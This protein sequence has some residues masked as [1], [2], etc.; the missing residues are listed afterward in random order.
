MLVGLG[1]A[2]LFGQD[3]VAPPPPGTIRVLILSG[4]SH[5]DWR[6]TTPFLRRILTDTRRFDVRISETPRG[7]T[8]ETLA[9]FEVVVDD[10]AG[11]RWGS[12][13]EKALEA[14]VKSGKGLVVTHGALG[15]FSGS[16]QTGDPHVDAVSRESAW[17]AFAKM[18]K[19][20]WPVPPPI[21]LPAVARFWDVKIAASTH[22]IV[23]GVKSE[24]ATADQIHRAGALLPGVEVLATARDNP[25]S[26]ADAH[27]EPVLWVSNYGLGRVVCVAL[28]HDLEAMQ[29]EAFITTFARGTEWAAT[30]RVTLASTWRPRQPE[31]GTVRALLVTGGHEHESAFYSLFEGCSDLDWLPVAT[32]QMAFESDLRKKYDVLILYDFSRDL[33]EKGKRNLRDFVESGK[34]VLVL[35]HA[36][37]SYQK[38]PW[39]YEEVVGGRYRLDAEGN[40]PASS[41]KD[42]QELF[43]TPEGAHPVTAGIGPFHLWD[44]PYKGMWI[45]SAI[46]PLLTTD[47]PSSDRAVAWISPYPKSRVVYI[48]LGHNHTTYGHP[49]Y[50]ALLH[51]AIL[52][53]A[54][55]TTP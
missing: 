47:S 4:Q 19:G 20:Q 43:V 40:T 14:F 23:Q 9:R 41:A 10:Y 25:R 46:K 38:W 7:L 17:P 44:E 48:Q 6:A 24:F 12:A 8:A 22:P 29:E 16:Q 34:G 37:L 31:T 36:I 27:P 45:S 26:G 42:K 21:G 35:H 13:T 11:P 33:D 49:A 1:C 30:G 18:T 39:W 50:R 15:S 3:P 28:G 54:G 51:N 2:S 5:H 55:R 53:G 32:S 52:W